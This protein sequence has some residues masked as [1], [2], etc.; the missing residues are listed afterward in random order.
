MESARLLLDNLH[1][2]IK[3]RNIKQNNM[4]NRFQ[5]AYYN[6]LRSSRTYLELKDSYRTINVEET[7]SI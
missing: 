7:E 2:N 1:S 5:M 6:F 4:E 3:Q